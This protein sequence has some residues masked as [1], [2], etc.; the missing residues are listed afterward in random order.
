MIVAGYHWVIDLRCWF[1]EN[2]EQVGQKRQ[3]QG[4]K[5]VAGCCSY[6]KRKVRTRRPFLRILSRTI[7]GRLLDIMMIFC[8]WPKLRH[9]RDSAI[10]GPCQ[11]GKNMQQYHTQP[12]RR[13][14]PWAR[15]AMPSHTAQ[16]ETHW[17]DPCE[18]LPGFLRS[19]SRREKKVK[20]WVNIRE[21]CS[22]C[23]FLFLF[24]LFVHSGLSFTTGPKAFLAAMWKHPH[25]HSPLAR[26][27]IVVFQIKSECH[28][29][30]QYAAGPGD[31]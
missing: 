6:H 5:R 18:G 11:R 21:R 10:F 15:S 19:F 14:Q 13:W 24:S 31:W 30:P 9:Y 3:N 22:F 8:C 1:M 2:Y 17:M 28:S 26:A 29:D 23:H 27:Q 25:T 7:L 12:I 4:S 16:W 20:S